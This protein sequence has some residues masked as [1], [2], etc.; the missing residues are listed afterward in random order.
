MATTL[1]KTWK[2]EDLF[3][4]PDD[5]KRY[6]IIDGALFEMPGPNSDHAI[7]VANLIVLLAPV[8]RV[9]G[10]RVLTA[11]L[12]IFLPGAEPV[13][14]DIVVLLADRL[15]LIGNRGI[16]GVPDLLL[17]VLSPSNPEH[18]RLRKRA[19]YARAG[20]REYWLVSPEAATVEVLVLAGDQYR[21]LVRAG[22]D[23]PI[24]SLVLPELAF[25]VS[26]IFSTA[27]PS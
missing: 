1:T 16:E 21:T 9:F 26:T 22:G 2:Y 23:E 12:D 10:G 4:L 11:P 7:A 8:V 18:D 27:M 24:R 5:G 3:D 17:E 19:L 13:Q 14:P 25:A 15:H 6:E 20:V